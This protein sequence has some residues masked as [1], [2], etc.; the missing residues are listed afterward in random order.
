[1]VFELPLHPGDV[2]LQRTMGK[3]VDMSFVRILGGHD[4]QKVR[5]FLENIL[6]LKYGCVQ[7]LK[8]K[9][10]YYLCGCGYISQCVVCSRE[11][12]LSENERLFQ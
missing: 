6:V 5:S 9:Y 2:S 3:Q 10:I 8:E 12:K 4:Q 1:M 7:S 11:G